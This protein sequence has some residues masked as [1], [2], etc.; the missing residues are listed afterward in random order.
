MGSEKFICEKKF[1]HILPNPLN[2][3]F[4]T[5]IS[6]GKIYGRIYVNYFFVF[7]NCSFI[8]QTTN[9]NTVCT[10][11]NCKTFQISSMCY[12]INELQK[13]MLRTI[14]NWD[15]NIEFTLKW[16]KL[17]DVVYLV[18]LFDFF[19]SDAKYFRRLS[20][21]PNTSL[22]SKGEH[23]KIYMIKQKI[24]EFIQWAPNRLKFTVNIL[25]KRTF[26]YHQ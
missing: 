22:C 25:I 3:S 23:H 26:L 8:F 15:Q 10:S 2:K 24:L 20:R 16:I 7:R 18:L 4:L 14:Q 5:F 17:W 19:F 1:K 13:H 6:G 11:Y 9:K 21:S 12:W